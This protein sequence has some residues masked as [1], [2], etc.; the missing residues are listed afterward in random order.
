MGFEST[1]ALEQYVRPRALLTGKPIS[2]SSPGY[3][4]LPA[5]RL[6]RKLDENLA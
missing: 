1:A 6:L 4:R 5:G 3:D 2:V